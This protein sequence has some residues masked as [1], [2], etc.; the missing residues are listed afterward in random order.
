MDLRLLSPSS[1]PW[2]C[3]PGKLCIASQCED[4][5][6]RA[7]NCVNDVFFMA[8]GAASVAALLRS[9]GSSKGA[10]RNRDGQCGC[11]DA[12]CPWRAFNRRQHGT[13]HD[14]YN[15]LAASLSSAAN[16]ATAGTLGGIT[17]SG[18]V[19]QPARPSP[20]LTFAWPQVAEFVSSANGHYALPRCE[21]IDEGAAYARRAC[22]VRKAKAPPAGGLAPA[23]GRTAASAMQAAAAIK[24]GLMKGLRRNRRLDGG[25][26][27]V[28]GGGRG[29][30]HFK[31]LHD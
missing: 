27:M 19:G 15:V 3:A 28:A 2:D 25:G 26:G 22:T 31:L 24:L 20:L 5:A 29:E 30:D 1:A 23:G 14:C 16:A 12:T 9:V 7:Y 13:G 8:S 17:A 4:S 10:S 21:E 6:W 18:A 11:F